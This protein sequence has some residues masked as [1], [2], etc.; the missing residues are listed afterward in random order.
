MCRSRTAKRGSQERKLH[1][2]IKSTNEIRQPRGRARQRHAGCPRGCRYSVVPP[3]RIR[4]RPDVISVRL[5]EPHI[6]NDQAGSRVCQPIP[7]TG[8]QATL[9]HVVVTYDQRM[10]GASTS[11]A[12]SPRCDRCKAI[13]DRLGQHLALALASE[14]DNTNRWAGVAPA[15]DPQPCA[16]TG[17][18]NRTRRRR[19]RSISLC[20]T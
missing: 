15:C 4:R 9:Q 7:T 2:L 8:F 6:G 1:D 14:V 13:V 18:S 10:A 11:T 17:A 19:R 20:S 5:P 12:N 16:D 3:A